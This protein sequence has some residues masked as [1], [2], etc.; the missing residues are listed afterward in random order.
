MGRKKNPGETTPEYG[1]FLVSLLLNSINFMGTQPPPQ[2]AAKK[3]ETNLQSTLSI[4]EIKELLSMALNKLT[5]LSPARWEEAVLKFADYHSHLLSNAFQVA[6]QPYPWSDVPLKDYASEVLKLMGFRGRFEKKAAD[7]KTWIIDFL[8][9]IISGDMGPAA[10]SKVISETFT[11]DP[12]KA[13]ATIRFMYIVA[14][15][16]ELVSEMDKAVKMLREK[17]LASD[18]FKAA[19][20]LAEEKYVV[21]S[22]HADQ[23]FPAAWHKIR[24]MA[25]DRIKGKGLAIPDAYEGKS[26]NRKTWVEEEGLAMVSLFQ[27]L[28]KRASENPFRLITDAIKGTLAKSLVKAIENDT[29][30]QIKFA[31]AKKRGM[32]KRDASTDVE[33]TDSTRLYRPLSGV[34][35]PDFLDTLIEKDNWRELIKGLTKEEQQ[36]VTMMAQERLTQ[37]EVGRRMDKSQAW[38]G[39]KL[40]IIRQKL[41]HLKPN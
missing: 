22:D 40:I 12:E 33:V 36:I 2:D 13:V 20:A 27:E 5:A 26:R 35:P 28:L 14:G 19:V 8:N 24:P 9:P 7:L 38:V 4:P 21:G 31:K 23:E 30:D 39:G 10:W 37:E 3:L 34:T 1:T 15:G 16:N 32:E 41:K 25:M 17:L 18:E 11:D 29:R 6:G